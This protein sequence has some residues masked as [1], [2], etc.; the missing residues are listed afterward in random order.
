[1]KIFANFKIKSFL[2]FAVFAISNLKAQIPTWSENIAPILYNNCTK[3]HIEGGIAPF[4]LVGYSNAQTMASS[5][6]YSVD[7][8]RMPPWPAIQNTKG[9]HMRES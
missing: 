1:M 6:A 7:L 2:F 8:K 9:M 3:C 4:S 5:I